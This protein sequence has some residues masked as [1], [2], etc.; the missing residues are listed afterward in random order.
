[1]CCHDIWVED[2]VDDDIG[3]ARR[4]KEEQDGKEMDTRSD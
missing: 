2:N 1:M 3:L 4:P